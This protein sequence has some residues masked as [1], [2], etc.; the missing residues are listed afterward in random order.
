MLLMLNMCSEVDA[1]KRQIDAL[2]KEISNRKEQQKKENNESRS[3][4][5]SLVSERESLR[6]SASI[7]YQEVS[8]LYFENVYFCY[9]SL[10]LS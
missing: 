7:S 6:K 2:K 9:S 8:R 4:L 3:K 10:E 1:L 5:E